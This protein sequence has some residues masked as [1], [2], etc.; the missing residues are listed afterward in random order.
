MIFLDYLIT[1]GTGIFE[2]T[3]TENRQGETYIVSSDG[4]VTIDGIKYSYEKD[5]DG[6]QTLTTGSGEDVYTYTLDENNNIII[7]GIEYAYENN[8]FVWKR[9]CVADLIEIDNHQQLIEIT[10][11]K[12]SEDNE[13]TS[14]FNYESWSDGGF[15]T[16]KRIFDKICIYTT[17]NVDTL[18]RNF[19]VA[20]YN[21]TNADDFIN[22]RFTQEGVQY[23]IGSEETTFVKGLNN[24]G[25]KPILITSLPRVYDNNGNVLHKEEIRTIDLNVSGGSCKLYLAGIYKDR[26]IKT[27]KD[28]DT[29]E[30]EEEDVVGVEDYEKVEGE[31]YEEIEDVI[32]GEVIYEEDDEED[33]EDYVKEDVE[34]T[35]VRMAYDGG[36]RASVINGK[37]GECKVKIISFGRPFSDNYTYRYTIRVGH[38]D[39]AS[40]YCPIVVEF[41]DKPTEETDCN[42]ISFDVKGSPGVEYTGNSDDTEEGGE[43]ETIIDKS[44]IL[45]FPY[46]GGE[47]S[48]QMNLGCNEDCDWYLED[49]DDIPD[50]LS[51]EYV[52]LGINISCKRNNTTDTDESDSVV[53]VEREHTLIFNVNGKSYDIT[54]NQ[55]KFQDFVILNPNQTM[56]LINAAQTEARVV[57]CIGS[58]LVYDKTS[59]ENVEVIN[60]GSYYLPEHWADEVIPD[61]MNISEDF[62][63]EY[64]V[65]LTKGTPDEEDY[66]EFEGKIRM[67]CAGFFQSDI[68]YTYTFSFW[69][70]N[71]ELF[72]KMK[73]WGIK[74]LGNLM[75]K[76]NLQ[77]AIGEETTEFNVNVKSDVERGKLN[78]VGDYNI[79]YDSD[80][81]NGDAIIQIGIE[82]LEENKPIDDIIIPYCSSSWCQVY[83]RYDSGAAYAYVSITDDNIYGLERKC[84]L[85]F[86]N[87]NDTS[88][89]LSCVVTNTEGKKYTIEEEKFEETKEDT[90]TEEGD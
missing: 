63:L 90:D 27:K 31:D 19:G 16:V 45:S 59:N 47:A 20:I 18:S 2:H 53:Y 6:N 11:L 7:D 33:E 15:I 82:G 54:V 83:M 28:N 10:V 17:A 65:K 46:V 26:V 52:P 68:N 69:S 37:Y 43:G 67:R 78:F 38:Y 64:T 23:M 56:E 9:K 22:I 77:S 70:G 74:E 30:N 60:C 73:E 5:S 84:R 58:P 75:W 40:Y 29:E 72:E 13:T 36:I 80:T 3:K 42:T 48:I 79:E 24:E 21:P 41:A 88:K 51:I 8:K 34:E 71:I 66:E 87:G 76:I 85:I 39:N 89:I 57:T 44:K 35:I 81:S 12:K 25:K 62:L 49:I 32:E 55:S 50:W 1:R 14:M 86:T 61:V 4:F